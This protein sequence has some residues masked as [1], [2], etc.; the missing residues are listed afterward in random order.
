MDELCDRLASALKITDVK[1]L[2]DIK[3][4]LYADDVA[5]IAHSRTELQKMVNV[6]AKFAE[7]YRLEVNLKPGKTEIMPIYTSSKAKRPSIRERGEIQ[8]RYRLMCWNQLVG[9]KLKYAFDVWRAPG[10]GPGY[11]VGAD[12]RSCSPCSCPAGTF[13]DSEACNGAT[14]HDPKQCVA[15][16][17]CSAGYWL[18]L[19]VCDGKNLS[20][21]GQ[22]GSGDACRACSCQ[23]G[24]FIDTTVCNGLIKADPGDAA[25]QA[26]HCSPGEYMSCNGNGTANS[27]K[28]CLA[29]PPGQFIRP[30]MCDGSGRM[31]PA[32]SDKCL[33]CTCKP[34][35]Y[36]NLSACA[37]GTSL[38]QPTSFCPLC[39]R[40]P[41]GQYI[42]G[43]CDGLSKEDPAD[44][45]SDCLCDAGQFILPAI[46]NGITLGS[47][48]RDQMCKSCPNC[49]PGEFV[50]CDGTGLA[51]QCTACAACAPGR[52]INLDLC[53]GSTKFDPKACSLCSCAAGQFIDITVCNGETFGPPPD[54]FC[55]ACSAC[56]VGQFIVPNVCSGKT[57]SDPPNHCAACSCAAGE[58]LNATACNGKTVGA[59]DP[60]QTCPTCPACD[61]GQY[62]ACDGKGR[63]P[64]CSVCSC[65]PGKFVDP[66]VCT[67]TTVGSPTGQCVSCLCSPG[68][69]LDLK[70]CNGRTVGAPSKDYCP[71]CS[72][73]GAGQFIQPNICNGQITVDPG[74][75][76]C[77]NC[78]ACVPG[79][80]IDAAVCDGSTLGQPDQAKYC[81]ACPKCN[82]TEF[83]DPSGCDGRSVSTSPPSSSLYCADCKCESGSHI[84]PDVCDGSSVGQV[85]GSCKGCDPCP[86]GS[87]INC[88]GQGTDGSCEPCQPCH[89][90]QYISSAVCDGLTLSEPAN[91]CASCSCA[92]GEYLELSQCTGR[93]I[94]Q[95][96]AACTRCGTCA[97]GSYVDC[98]GSTSGPSCTACSTCQNGQY[99]DPQVCN[100]AS[101]TDPGQA[102]CAACQ[103]R[104]GQVI[105]VSECTGL[106]LG[107]PA[108]ACSNCDACDK[109][110][111]IDCPGNTEERACQACVCAQGEYINGDLCNGKSV[112]QPAET[113]V[114]CP[115]CALGQYVYCPGNALN[116]DCKACPVCSAGSYIDPTVCNGQTLSPPPPSKACV[117]CK[118]Q[119]GQKLDL[120]ECNGASIGQTD[121]ACKACS[122]CETGQY[123]A[124]DGTGSQDKCAACPSCPTLQYINPAVCDGST[125]GPPVFDACLPCSC[126]PGERID[127]KTCNGKTT[128][129]SATACVKCESCSAGFYV[130]CPGSSSVSGCKKCNSCN[131][132]QFIDPAVCDGSTTAS[133]PNRCSPCVCEAGQYVNLLGGFSQGCSGTTV[134]QP[135]TACGTCTCEA[136]TYVDGNICDGTMQ[137]SPTNNEHCKECVCVEGEWLSVENCTG[138]TSPAHFCGACTSCGSGFMLDLTVCNGTMTKDTGGEGDRTA[139]VP[140]P[141][142]D[143][144]LDRFLALPPVLMYGAPSLVGAMLLCMLY[145]CCC[146][147][148]RRV[149]PESKAEKDK[150][151]KKQKRTQTE[152]RDSLLSTDE[153]KPQYSPSS[154]HEESR[155]RLLRIYRKYNESKVGDVDKI[156][157]MYKGKESTLWDA[158]ERKYPGCTKE[159]EVAVPTSS[160]TSSAAVQAVESN[161]PSQSATRPDQPVA[162]VSDRLMAFYRKHEPGKATAKQV[163]GVL[164]RYK[165]REPAMWEALSDKYGVDP[166]QQSQYE[167]PAPVALE[168]EVA[169]AKEGDGTGLVAVDLTAGEESR[170]ELGPTTGWEA[171]GGA[172]RDRSQFESFFSSPSKELPPTASADSDGPSPS[173]LDT[174]PSMDLFASEMDASPQRPTSSSAS[175]SGS[176]S[177]SPSRPAVVAVTLAVEALFGSPSNSGGLFDEQD[178]KDS[179]LFEKDAIFV[180][181]DTPAEAQQ[182]PEAEMSR[183]FIQPKQGAEQPSTIL[184]ESGK[185][186]SGLQEQQGDKEAASFFEAP[187]E[188]EEVSKPHTQPQQATKHAVVKDNV[189]PLFGE[190]GQKDK[191]EQKKDVL[192]DL[193]GE[194]DTGKV[195]A[196][197]TVTVTDTEAHR[198]DDDHLFGDTNTK[199]DDLFGEANTKDDNDIFATQPPVTKEYFALSASATERPERP[200]TQ[201]VVETERSPEDDDDLFGSAAPSSL[202]AGTKDDHDMAAAGSATDQP[203]IQP[204]ESA[205]GAVMDTEEGD[206]DLFGAVPAKLSSEATPAVTCAAQPAESEDDDDLFATQA[207]AMKDDFSESAAATERLDSQTAVETERSP[208]DDELFGSAAP[209]SLPAVEA[210]PTAQPSVLEDDDDLFAT[211][212]SQPA[213][214]KDDDMAAAGSATDQPD[215]QLSVESASGAAMNTEEGDDDLFGS[216]VLAK[217]STEATPAVTSAAQPER[218]DSQPAVETE[219]SPEDD[220]VFGPAAVE[221]TPNAQLPVLEDDDDLF[222]ASS[223]QPAA[224]KDDDDDERFAVAFS[225]PT[226]TNDDDKVTVADSATEESKVQLHVESVPAAA[227]DTEESDDDMFGSAAPSSQPAGTKDDDDDDLFAASFQTAGAI[228][229]DDI[230]AAVSSTD[231]PDHDVQL[232]VENAPAAARD[233]GQDDD[234]LYA[235]AVPAKLSTEATPTVTSAAQPVLEND[236]LFATQPPVSK[237]DVTESAAATERPESQIAVET[238]RSP[239]DD[240]ELFSSA[241]SSSLPAV[242]ATPTAQPPVLEDDVTASAAAA[243]ERPDS[244]S[245]IQT[246]RS[247]EDDD[248]LFGSATV[249]AI[250]T[251]QH[252]IEDDDDMFVASSFQP[253]GT[254]DDDDDIAAPGSSTE[255]SDEQLPVE[256]A[257]G[258]DLSASA[259]P[260]TLSTEATTAVSSAVQPPASEVDDHLFAT[261]S[262]VTKEDVSVSAAAE[263]PESQTA[264]KTEG[265]PEDDDEL[266]GSASPSSLPA[267]EAT[268]TV[269]PPVLEDG[270]TASAA[271][272]TTERPDSQPAVETERSSED[273]E[274]LFG[275]AAPSSLP[276]VEAT[277]TAQP[278][279]LEDDDLFAASSSQPAGTKDG[280]DLAAAGSATDQPDRDVQLPVE[281]AAAMRDAEE[282]D[283]DIFCSAVPAKLSR[284]ATPA[285]SS[286]VQPAESEDDDYLFAT[287]AP[288]M[289]DDVTESAAAT[290]RPDSQTAVET[291]RS[292]EDDELFGSAAPSSLPAVEATPTAQ[293]SVLEDDDDL[294]AT[295]SS[296]PA[297]TKDDD[298]MAAA[299]SA[300]DQ[301]D[302]QLP[303]ESA[304]GAAVNTEEGDDDLFGSAVLAKVSTEATPAVTSAAQPAVSEDDD[305][306]FAT[307]PPVT[308][309]DVTESTAATER[310]DPQAAV[311]IERSPEDDDDELFGSAAPSSLPA[312]E[313]TPTGQPPVLE[314]N[315]DLFASSSSQPAGTKDDDD[316][317]AVAER[318]DSQPAVETERSAEDEEQDLFVSAVDGAAP[319]QSDDEDDLFQSALIAPSTA[320]SSAQGPVVD[321]A[322]AQ[323]DDEDDLFQSALI[324]SG[325]SSAQGI[326]FDATSASR[327]VDDIFDTN[328]AA[329]DLFD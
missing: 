47:P 306:L 178:A 159:A 75:A 204:V 323:S 152:E 296:Q 78:A 131:A 54:V 314:D 26:C 234:D 41:T 80:W 244:N 20:D 183:A 327:N 251:A 15:C 192:D 253:A 225:Q 290:E 228:D 60:K 319:A 150:A 263:R 231:Q 223:S 222:A 235:S 172:G 154:K 265:S 272:A 17:E 146:R 13:I 88:P 63:G 289:T 248:E 186:T 102:A 51:P 259:V 207:P 72:T 220:E 115:R 274:Q 127:S 284:E 140:I 203:G 96:A 35:S 116:S 162:S 311:E 114:A 258:D 97:P 236:D 46:C 124:C 190:R 157:Q 241:A 113:C 254:K 133:P 70:I 292:S 317:A 43:N 165:G 95:P 295:S 104:A 48:P 246:E 141:G 283:D 129:Q 67:G 181:S 308:K 109:G 19:D 291:E 161:Q 156:L 301:P 218:P 61:V 310:P 191:K 221:A 9:A 324:A 44:H 202:P 256:S 122:R 224:T 238:E 24:H 304:S 257:P 82:V 267:V 93:I 264:V 270:V 1:R 307:Q 237:D 25:C 163:K 174:S 271:A 171:G 3:A 196:S 12:E 164:A 4:L 173:K 81:R 293:P 130:D 239:E 212:S 56:A 118:C 167:P 29:C 139:C 142:P 117:S 64:S 2:N 187:L 92:L 22:S 90:G 312:V 233:R 111:W 53:D 299:G 184:A 315:D 7:D 298:D 188:E 40:C 182:A 180:P 27:C 322:P 45:C 185:E 112:A 318:P 50:N 153:P 305:D 279:V 303:V 277:P 128:G 252:P 87:W 143:S 107:Q 66:K 110:Q 68:T 177:S 84:D 205:P 14:H 134:G 297:G 77:Q 321:A 148:R 242:E 137:G 255:Q 94:D 275:S 36:Q 209:S 282:G 249:E 79:N 8:A 193:F 325:S 55:E 100:G 21:S 170:S 262:P 300:T 278:P 106:T 10:C 179:G 37:A 189:S 30:D 247:P 211:S 74:V 316:M 31:D 215:A 194:E 266:F 57:T 123:I 287:Q 89:Q 219:C 101:L 69:W 11:F 42:N 302:T 155:Q 329:D 243:T 197:G 201:P 23:G 144:L 39:S 280:D 260:V 285:V 28:Q 73:C 145:F 227:R 108:K 309:D 91:H 281:S 65:D 268:L 149:A 169:K 135:A 85:A 125:V 210:T 199:D 147:R 71:A 269:Q 121:R 76:A 33:P 151:P 105:S 52:F 38:G 326:A 213:G 34:G 294:F 320:S 328:D 58:Y 119:A 138:L 200:D 6:V 126:Q 98:P 62:I 229:H 216:A 208:E 313:A 261:Q 168:Q 166:P 226:G 49:A 32:N 273:D 59:P 240:D 230:A 245:L 18:S 103:C 288:G 198:K 195:K 176:A 86:A 276:A 5:L 132:G 232:S 206:D 83:I 214:T 160:S 99:I 120:T 250:S 217:V 158:L 175:S 286:A 136:G 16:S